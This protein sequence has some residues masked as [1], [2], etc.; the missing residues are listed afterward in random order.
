MYYCGLESLMND[1]LNC[2]MLLVMSSCF[3]SSENLPVHGN[4]II[5]YSFPL[6]L[7][8]IHAWTICLN[9]FNIFSE[10][11]MTVGVLIKAI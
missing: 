1:L 8:F 5:F 4:A 11:N 3:I 6:Q 2:R 7:L 10:W 9:L